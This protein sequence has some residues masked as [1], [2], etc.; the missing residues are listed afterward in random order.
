MLLSDKVTGG[1]VAV[2]GGLAF[3]YGSQL[4]PVPG[5]QIG[6]SAFPMVIGAG[7]VLCGGL[8][9]LGIGHRFEEVAEADLASHTAPEQ[10]APLPAW[11]NW[12]ALLPPA[13]LAFYALVSETLG[14][15][16][17]SAIMVL[18]AS[19]AFG[20]RPKLAVPLAIIA[21]FVINLIFLKLL[22]VPLPGGIL[23]FPW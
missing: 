22:R 20:A 5:Q 19:L 16:P 6:P 4:P 18:V 17:T 15:L 13:L 8:I 23:P 10:L 11:R 9:M 2:L 3:A 7:L 1:V 21:P 14:F 12:L